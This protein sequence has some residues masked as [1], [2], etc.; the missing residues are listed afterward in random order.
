MVLMVI[1]DFHAFD[2]AVCPNEADAVF[3]IDA[4][5]VLAS[6]A[7]LKRFQPVA[8]RNPEVVELL[9][10]VELLKFAQGYFLD[11]GRQFRRLVSL[12]NPLGSFAAE[13][14]DHLPE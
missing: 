3:I 11:V 8:R 7:P 9:G 14:K 10:D 4:D 5:G 2:S 13:G 1:Y 12:M 6:A